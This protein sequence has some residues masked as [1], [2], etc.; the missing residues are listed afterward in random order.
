MLI[1]CG[2]ALVY[3][4]CTSIINGARGVDDVVK[5]IKAGYMSALRVRS[6]FLLYPSVLAVN[7]ST[8]YL[9]DPT[10]NHRHCTAI[11]RAGV[12]GALHQFGAVRY[13]S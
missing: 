6:L 2:C 1:M 12:V 7:E 13:R 9:D 3:L 10:F 11:S 4:T 8:G 5:T